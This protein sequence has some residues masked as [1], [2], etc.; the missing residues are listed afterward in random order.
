[1]ESFISWTSCRIFIPS[2]TKEIIADARP[3]AVTGSIS[4]Q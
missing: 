3:T 2:G 1:M 4:R